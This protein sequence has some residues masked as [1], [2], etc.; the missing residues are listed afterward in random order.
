M[1][2]NQNLML[3][4]FTYWSPTDQDGYI[5]PKASYK[6]TD[7]WLLETSAGFFF[8]R[9]NHTFFGQFEDNSSIALAARYS[10]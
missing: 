5:R 9:H 7:H 8:G 2:M 3:S 1:L 10:F 4:L 6:L